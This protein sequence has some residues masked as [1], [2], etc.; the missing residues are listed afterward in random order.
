MLGPGGRMPSAHRAKEDAA[1]TGHW[2][3]Q[4]SG[5]VPLQPVTTF[6]AWRIPAGGVGSRSL[7]TTNHEANVWEAAGSCHAVR[8]RALDVEE[9]LASAGLGG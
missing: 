8:G 9:I 2:P 1:A 4:A 6:P 3:Q 5:M 7:I